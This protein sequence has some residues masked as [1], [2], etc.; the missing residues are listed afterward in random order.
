M[1]PNTENEAPNMVEEKNSKYIFKILN[2][3]EEELT[4]GY[5]EVTRQNFKSKFKVKT[6]HFQII[7]NN[8]RSF[9][10]VTK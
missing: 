1:T 10:L 5:K 8:K 7:A 3:P 2:H 6:K 9:T 4:Q